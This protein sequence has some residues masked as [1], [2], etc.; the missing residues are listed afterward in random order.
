MHGRCGVGL[1]LVDRVVE[2]C[3]AN[4]ENLLAGLTDDVR[5]RLVRLLRKLA[6]V[7]ARGGGQPMTSLAPPG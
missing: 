1:E 2:E 3:L 4:E 7:G 6:R 5:E